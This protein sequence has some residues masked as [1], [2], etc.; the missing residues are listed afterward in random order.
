MTILD[1][2]VWL[3]ARA[4]RLDLALADEELTAIHLER[5]GQ[6][7]ER[8]DGIRHILALLAGEAMAIGGP[9]GLAEDL[10]AQITAPILAS[11]LAGRIAHLEWADGPMPTRPLK[12]RIRN[13]D[14]ML[15]R[16]RQLTQMIAERY[17]ACGWDATVREEWIATMLDLDRWVRSEKARLEIALVWEVIMA[18]HWARTGHVMPREGQIAFLL[19]KVAERAS[20][21]REKKGIRPALGSF[22]AALGDPGLVREV[23]REMECW[24]ETRDPSRP[25]R[26]LM[27]AAAL[28]LDRARLELERV[29]DNHAALG[30]QLN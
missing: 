25:V 10:S 29:L 12:E 18:D 3:A 11:E 24:C 27:D 21:V 9:P 5:R 8:I 1:F 19:G 17:A 2:E 30:G 20:R 4:T 15:Q 26:R 22:L 6:P 13:V 14:L 28:V 16:V 23:T 7:L